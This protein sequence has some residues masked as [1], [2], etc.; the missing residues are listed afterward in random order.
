[1]SSYAD[2]DEE[3][4]V[5]ERPVKRQR[6]ES[7]GLPTCRQLF[8]EEIDLEIA[9]RE[10]LQKT[11]QSRIT[12][13]LL[14]QD[15]AAR[16]LTSSENT[17]FRDTSLDALEAI[18]IPCNVLFNR[19]VRPTERLVPVVS[20]TP[21]VEPL[22]SAHNAA[23]PQA[24]PSRTRGVN[25]TPARVPPKRLLFLRNNATNPPQ[26]VK[27]ACSDCARTDFSSLQGLL[28]HCRLRHKR[29]FGSHDECVQSS[30]I[31]VEGEEQRN[32]VV[33][34]GTEVAGISIPGLRRLFEIAVGGNRD[35]LPIP[36]PIAPVEPEEEQVAAEII[37]MPIPREEPH[38]K[39]GSSTPLLTRT[40][41][42]HEDTPALA[43]FLGRA[44]KQRCINVDMPDQYVD[45][46][47]NTTETSILAKRWRA[48]YAGRSEIVAPVTPEEDI[49]TLSSPKV[50]QQ[51]VDEQPDSEQTISQHVGTRFHIVARV[52]VEDQSFWITPG[53]RLQSAPHHTHRWRLSVT[54]PSYSLPLT[55]FLDKV[56]IRCL[57]DPAPSTLIQPMTL[58]RPPF[59]ATSTTD[60]PF[61]ASLEFTWASPGRNAPMAIEHWVE[62]DPLHLNTPVS[63]DKQ[64]FDVELDRNTELLAARQ[65]SAV[66]SWDFDDLPETDAPDQAAPTLNSDHTISPAE[67]YLN[68]QKHDSPDNQR[69]RS[70]LSQV[71]LT[72]KDVKGRMTRKMPYHVA[73]TP[74]HF[75]N[76]VH[77]RRKAVEWA[78]ARTLHELY[79]EACV[80]D[81]RPASDGPTRATLSIADVYHW[82]ETEGHFPR[83]VKL[84]ISPTSR[85][86]P[87]APNVTGDLSLSV[88]S[89]LFCHR[90]GLHKSC[91]PSIEIPVKQEANSHSNA[92][93]CAVFITEPA[94]PPV[95]DISK[96]LQTTVPTTVVIARPTSDISWPPGDLLAIAEPSMVLAIQGLLRRDLSCFGEIISMP[97]AGFGLIGSR[98]PTKSQI[99]EQLAP[100]AVLSLLTRSVAKRLL[101]G[102]VAVYRE[103]ERASQ[104]HRRTK[105]LANQRL[106]T[107]SHLFRMLNPDLGHGTATHM[108]AVLIGRLGSRAEG[109]QVQEN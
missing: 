5:D 61:L 53:K 93:P 12:W 33:A 77:G 42:Y 19:N 54:S 51:T 56:T 78:R 63:G 38:S 11:I 10:R 4:A 45:P 14:L 109:V 43:P 62:L 65:D 83:T 40:L 60:R 24:A 89:G 102:A 37:D 32:W 88:R 67:R 94:H 25:R 26:I 47:S 64:V 69:L 36:L 103:D 91:H 97:R 104:P 20:S 16:A 18:E 80:D 35:V 44:P 92:E 1:M 17:V 87:S 21:Q 48:R 98:N 101:G 59:V 9:L 31:L 106:L 82:L 29:E 86:R 108:A 7:A 22:P 84:K 52:G 41:G 6:L 79:K 96:L 73:A 8:L 71:P 13:A 3:T 50:L 23:I 100:L 55:S 30:A 76:L 28:N 99:E 74:M 90:C 27:L 72:L 39:S 57:S 75:L 81:A 58:D 68:D 15:N 85:Q 95:V 70:L 49:V 107:P 105:G 2:S 34:N 46:F 66:V